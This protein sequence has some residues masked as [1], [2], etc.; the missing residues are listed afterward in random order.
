MGCENEQETEINEI[1]SV[2]SGIVYIIDSMSS[3]SDSSR[4]FYVSQNILTK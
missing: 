3:Y 2:S 4:V 1:N